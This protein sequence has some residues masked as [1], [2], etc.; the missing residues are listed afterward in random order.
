MVFKRSRF[1]VYIQPQYTR[2]GCSFGFF[3]HDVIKFIYCWAAGD[4][5]SVMGKHQI[6]MYKGFGCHIEK[7]RRTVNRILSTAVLPCNRMFLLRFKLTVVVFLFENLLKC[8]FIYF[9]EVC[10]LVYGHYYYF[11]FQKYQIKMCR[12]S[13]GIAG[14]CFLLFFSLLFD[15][16]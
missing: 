11:F 8:A 14:L 3:P 10:S 1:G 2:C 13:V 12:C 5:T 6:T 15:N 7:K 16:R 4:V 9:V